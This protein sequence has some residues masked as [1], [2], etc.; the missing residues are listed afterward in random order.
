LGEARGGK[1]KMSNKH[2][3][4]LTFG[5]LTQQDVHAALSYLNRDPL[6]NIYLI[7][8]LQTRGLAG[9]G[10]T[11]W[12]AW[13]QGLLRGILLV[14]D[15]DGSGV[16]Y[17]A[18]DNPRVLARLGELAHQR[19]AETLVGNGTYIQPAT[20]DLDAQV[21]VHAK[22]L[23]FYRADPEGIV[24]HYDHPVRMAAK[25][26][27][28]A[29]VAL[30]QEYEFARKDR[31]DGEIEHEITRAMDR[32]GVYFVSE[33]EGRIVSAARIFPQTDRAGVIGAAR[34][35]PE[36]RGRGIYLSVR[37]ACFEHLFRQGKT[38]LGMFV[39]ANASM[40][41][42]LDKQGGSILS[43]WLIV[44]LKAKPPLRQRILPQRIRRWGL[45]VRDYFSRR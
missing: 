20:K 27:I 4:G 8:S 22:R 2:S 37:T 30:Y 15:E 33:S 40:H 7:H 24:R 16:G 9:Q 23:H 3:G 35:L 6:H 29:L 45:R 31:M 36:F 43:E 38:G 21:G 18:G 17:L 26:D 39:D 25:Q 5:L 34:T 10:A 11:F 12:G 13:G 1:K 19:G 28:P 32:S 41:R 14:D 42:V 44:Q